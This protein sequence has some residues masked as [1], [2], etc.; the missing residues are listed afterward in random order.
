[1]RYRKRR[2]KEEEERRERNIKESPDISSF[3]F[4]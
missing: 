1:M 3:I 4:P 2:K